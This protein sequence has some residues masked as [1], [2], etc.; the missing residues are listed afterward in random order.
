MAAS[1]LLESEPDATVA[2]IDPQPFSPARF[3]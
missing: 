1:L 3:R 2:H